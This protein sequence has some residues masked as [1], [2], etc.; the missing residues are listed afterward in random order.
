MSSLANVVMVQGT[1]SHAG[2]SVLATALCRIFAQ[3]GY[4]VAPFKAQNMSLNSFVT[5]DGGEIGRSQAVQAAAAMVEPR[6]EMNPVLLK[7]EAEARSQVV[8][9]GRPQARK[10]AREYYELKQQL[11]IHVT[12]A[13]D[14]LRREYD[15]VVI[16]GAGSPAEI[17]LKQH[18]I[19]NMRVARHTNAPVLLVGDIDRGGVFAQ[20]VGTMVLLEPEERALVIGHVINKF[21]GDP[22]LLTS[23]LHLLEEHTGVPAIGLL[24]Y[25]FDIHIPEE[26]SLGLETVLPSDHETL[27]DIAVIRLPRIANL[28]DFDPLRHEP[29]A[30]VRY[31]R[32]LDD[33]GQPD[34]IVLPGSKTT[35]DDLD[36]LRRQG[37]ADR[38]VRAREGGTPVIGI[39]AGFQMLGSELRDPQAVESSK[40]STPGLGLLATDTMFHAAKVTHQVT[41]RVT[42]A[43]GL[44]RG[45]GGATLTGYEIHMGMAD[46]TPAAGPIAIETRSGQPVAALDGALDDDGLTLGTY[47]HGLFHNRT[48]RRSILDAVA[49]RKGVALPPLRDDVDPDTEYNNLAAFVREHLDMAHIRR[50]MGLPI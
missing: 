15:V 7:P 6:V 44:L 48:L 1:S 20:I 27:V 10:S 5:P 47:L 9:L 31:V 42:Q 23:G 49:N 17:N 50:A 35:V 13:L 46:G 4:A 18:D 45:C 36:W 40:P 25:F 2:K 21:R 29:G 30:R 38:V 14:T 43:R 8:V 11:W 39:C 34:L 16:E 28:D 3:D 24:P 33:F 26:D 22:A 37:L 41:A 12:E 32:T 19:V